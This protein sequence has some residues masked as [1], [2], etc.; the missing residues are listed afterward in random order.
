[1]PPILPIRIPEPPLELRLLEERNVDEVDD[2]ERCGGNGQASK[3]EVARVVAARFPELKGASAAGRIASRAL[4]RELV[5]C[6]GRGDGGAAGCLSLSAEGAAIEL[7]DRVWRVYLE[8]GKSADYTWADQPGAALKIDSADTEAVNIDYGYSSESIPVVE[9]ANC[10]YPCVFGGCCPCCWCVHRNIGI[11]EPI[12][13]LC[14][15]WAGMT[16]G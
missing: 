7:E 11:P 15:R 5:R 12:D 1:M 3:A 16:C 13:W 9:A 10:F 6:G 4:L 14:C 8:P 2:E